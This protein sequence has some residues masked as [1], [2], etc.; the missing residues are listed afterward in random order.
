[1]GEKVDEFANAYLA[2]NSRFQQ[3]PQEELELAGKSF[4][5]GMTKDEVLRNIPQGFVAEVT[6][7]TH[8]LIIKEKDSNLG[9]VIRFDTDIDQASGDAKVR[10]LSTGP[11]FIGSEALELAEALYEALSWLQNGKELDIIQTTILNGEEKQIEISLA[12]RSVRIYLFKGGIGIS[13][14]LQEPIF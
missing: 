3:P 5:L 12:K 13:T 6:Q 14:V 8:T 1:V 9:I 10:S 7:Y 4:W 2:V 11:S